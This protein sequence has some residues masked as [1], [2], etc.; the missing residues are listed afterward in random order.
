MIDTENIRR[1]FTAEQRK[2]HAERE[3]PLGDFGEAQ[4]IANMAAFLVS[5]R[6]KYITGTVAVVDGGGRHYAF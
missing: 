4:D 2:E 6:A 5:P 3:I 1:F